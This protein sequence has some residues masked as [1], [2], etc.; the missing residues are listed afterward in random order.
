MFCPSLAPTRI[1]RLKLNTLF[2]IFIWCSTGEFDCYRYQMMNE[3]HTKRLIIQWTPYI[4]NFLCPIISHTN[5]QYSNNFQF[6]ILYFYSQLQKTTLLKTPK[7]RPIRLPKRQHTRQRNLLK[8]QTK[9]KMR[10]MKTKMMMKK[11]KVKTN[12]TLLRRNVLNF[13]LSSLMFTI[14]KNVSKE[15][16]RNKKNLVTKTSTTRK[17]VLKN[18][19]TYNTLLT[20]VLLQSYSSSWN[21]HHLHTR[22]FTPLT[23]K[24]NLTWSSTI[25]ASTPI[26]IITYNI[27]IVITCPCEIYVLFHLVHV[28]SHSIPF[29]S[30][31]KLNLS[32]L[33][34]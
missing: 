1:N 23:H 2:L 7:K 25:Y 13:H 34:W 22:S 5:K 27:P 18:S 33:L 24:K 21:N 12:S 14:T 31:D 4:F 10:M 16:L 26:P 17:T 28:A 15:L 11:K 6:P 29:H 32:L 3:Y 30:N 9:K 8:M 20:I 19:S